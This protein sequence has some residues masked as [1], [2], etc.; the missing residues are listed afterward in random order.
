MEG[1][2][3]N[4]S[5]IGQKSLAIALSI[6]FL[7]MVAEVAG[8][9]ISNSLALLSDAGHMLTDIL[10][11][12][13]SLFA[14]KFGERPATSKKTY[15]F[16]RLEILAALINGGF[17]ILISLYIAYNAYLRL[18]KPPEI[19]APVMM[20]I[21]FLGLV[22]NVF[23]VFLLR[24]TSRGNLNVRGAYLHIIGDALSSIGVLAGG[25]IILLTGWY[26]TDSILSLM[27]SVVI[28]KGAF[29]LI[30]D[31]VDIL[32]EAAPKGINLEEVIRDIKKIEG[33]KDVHHIHLWTIT[34]GIYAMSGHVLI[35]DILMSKSAQILENINSLLRERFLIDHTTLQ[36]ECE[37][38]D[39]GP[40]C[41]LERNS[42]A[43]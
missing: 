36:F 12:A 21:A 14:I 20:V 42:T 16:Y 13:L 17:L 31:S 23:A 37:S 32:L 33:V 1:D 40:V 24:K 34:S 29:G 3:I 28:I 43:F 26:I 10:A 9:I 25:S 7:M 22:V 30:R 11:L 18:L 6:T 4:R 35:E 19:N 5:S 27:I 39:E 41:R 38:C 2:F 15:G 8:G